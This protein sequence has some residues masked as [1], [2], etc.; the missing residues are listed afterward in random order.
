MVRFRCSVLKA[1]IRGITS[2]I[3]LFFELIFQKKRNMKEFLNCLILTLL[4]QPTGNEVFDDFVF[5][6][7]FYL[8]F[9]AAIGVLLLV[10]LNEP[11]RKRKRTQ[12]KL[13]FLECVLVFC[14]NVLDI[15]LV[16]LVTVEDEWATYAFFAALTIN[17][18]LYLLIILNW[19]VCVD[20]C[21]NR[22]RDHIRI[23]YKHAAIP[24]LIVTVLDLFQSLVG[25]G[26]LKVTFPRDIL[27]NTVQ[28]VKVMIEISYVLMAIYLV[29][30]YE[31]QRKEP[32]FL[33]IDAFIIPFLFGCLVRFYD[34]SF[35][36]F[37][38][39]L[40]YLAMR[41][42]DKYIDIETGIFNNNYLDCIS[43]HWDKKGITEG[44]ALI[45]RSFGNTEAL[46]GILKKIQ[47]PDCFIIRSE[48]ECF[49]MLSGFLRD[50]AVKI[51]EL[52]VKENAAEQEPSFV[53]EIRVLRRKEGQTMHE[54]S[55]LIKETVMQSASL[56]K[57]GADRI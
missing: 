29:V 28:T 53:P 25:F 2:V 26:F 54:F 56:E 6:S 10:L 1:S 14:Q 42:R 24:I 7:S 36:G 18:V 30:K 11:V 31:K 22:S 34:A 21:L 8:E 57:G 13:V 12:D 33:R 19:L 50:S 15:L 9:A 55:A 40:T 45:I 49:V 46:K 4:Y 38:V 44:T 39:I 27:Y 3:P 35:L 23:R 32:R 20:F 43:E 37:G 51:A 41:R 48:N 17:E 16:P 47:I 5:Y 52:M